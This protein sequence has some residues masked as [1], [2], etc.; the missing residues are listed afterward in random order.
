MT[1]KLFP[2]LF[3]LGLLGVEGIGQVAPPPPP[4]VATGRDTAAGPFE[5]REGGF[6]VQFPGP[7]THEFRD[8]DVSFGKARIHTF[9]RG[10]ALGAYTVGYLDFPTAIKDKFDLDTRFDVM[11]EAQVKRV[12]GRVMEENEHYHGTNYGRHL[13]IESEEITQTFRVIM[14]EQRLFT[15]TVI[16]RGKLSRQTGALK[17]SNEQRIKRFMD[18][19]TVTQIPK[20][21]LT[22]IELPADFGVSIEKDLFRS[23]YFGVSMQ[24]PKGW[25]ILAAAESEVLLEIGKEEIGRRNRRLA[26]HITSGNS[27]ILATISKTPIEESVSPAMIVIGAEKAPYPNFLATAAAKTFV[28][29]FLDRAEK[30]IKQPTSETIGGIPFSWAET[31]DS[32][33]KVK[34]RIYFA[35]VKGVAFEVGL[36]YSDDADLGVMLKALET[37]RL[38]PAGK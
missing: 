22:A 15:L 30:V 38:E 21:E 16:T 36:T 35:N 3:V 8:V 9:T 24:L 12:N 10:T 37:I 19:F 26:D 7:P 11:R 31:Y 23:S 14:V 27:R 13:V 34:Q 20:P 18:S 6:K 1:R 2:I 25:H 32:A 29:A 33:S 4:R 17:A 28:S 5:S